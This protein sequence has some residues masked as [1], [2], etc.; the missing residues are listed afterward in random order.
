MWSK[1]PSIL[2][3]TDDYH[4]I[5]C[6]YSYIPSRAWQV[7]NIS[8]AGVKAGSRP[9]APHILI[10][11]CEV[12]LSRESY[13]KSTSEIK[14]SIASQSILLYHVILKITRRK[15]Q[16]SLSLFSPNARHWATSYDMRTKANLN[17]FRNC[18]SLQ[19][20][21][22]ELCILKTTIHITLLLIN[23]SP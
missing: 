11:A 8:G 20:Y 21:H 2:W 19:S 16:L 4:R 18:T 7:Y 15:N 3:Y 13:S 1:W 10:G 17:V 22:V 6:F 23:L 5:E 9:S 12:G 14:T